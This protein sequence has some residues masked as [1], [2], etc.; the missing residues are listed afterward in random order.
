MSL[1]TCPVLCFKFQSAV[2]FRREINGAKTDWCAHD[3]FFVCFMGFE[4]YSQFPTSCSV[5]IQGNQKLPGSGGQAF[6]LIVFFEGSVTELTSPWLVFLCSSIPWIPLPW[7]L[8]LIFWVQIS[9]DILCLIS[10][11]IFGVPVKFG[12][13]SWGLKHRQPQVNGQNGLNHCKTFSLE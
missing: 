2:Y 3:P 10:S 11:V 12:H 13:V 5:L 6:F 8:P 7:L 9:W 4:L 1:S